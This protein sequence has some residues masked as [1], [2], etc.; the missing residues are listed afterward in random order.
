MKKYLSLLLISGILFT[1]NVVAEPLSVGNSDS[2]QSILS[3]Q[4]GNRV[5]IMLTS[6]NEL[7]GKVGEVNS[8]IVHLI[9]LSG[10]EFFDAVTAIKKIEAVVIRTKG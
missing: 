3:A 8:K 2:I 5:T 9:E 6:G 1:S 7:T 4:K 10:K